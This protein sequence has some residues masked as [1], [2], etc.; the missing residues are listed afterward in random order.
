MRYDPA[1]D[2]DDGDRTG[3]DVSSGD[4]DQIGMDDDANDDDNGNRIGRD[5]DGGD[6]DQIGMD[7]DG[8]D[9]EQI[10]T[11]IYN[12]DGN[13]GDYI[14]MGIYNDDG[15]N[16]NQ[17]GMGNGNDDVD[18]SLGYD[19]ISMDAADEDSI[20]SHDRIV[21]EGNAW[22][23]VLGIE[24]WFATQSVDAVQPAEREEFIFVATDATN[25]TG[26]NAAIICSAPTMTMTSARKN[27]G[28]WFETHK[29]LR[30]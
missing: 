12:D 10:R 22:A 9:G 1:D 17:N 18:D 25:R 14:G 30:H 15:D 6:D 19:G 8:D 13:D 4:G 11:G 16:V 24:R 23:S 27:V 21:D 26:M 5:I 28:A 29:R 3:S 2:G 7:D 20:Y